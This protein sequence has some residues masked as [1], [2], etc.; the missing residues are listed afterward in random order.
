[1]FT[2]AALPFL[3]DQLNLLPC[4][5]THIR[6]EIECPVPNLTARE[7]APAVLCNRRPTMSA[8]IIKASISFVTVAASAGSLFAISWIGLALLGF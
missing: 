2:R 8:Q 7:M 3:L 6:P 1:M 4:A 5:A